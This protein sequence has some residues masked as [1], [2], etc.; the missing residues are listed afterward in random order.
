MEWLRISIQT[1]VAQSKATNDSD[2]WYVD[3]LR[4][5]IHHLDQWWHF[6]K[7]GEWRPK[8]AQ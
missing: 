7:T 1:R 8:H 4:E 6:N 3:R 5:Q 2:R